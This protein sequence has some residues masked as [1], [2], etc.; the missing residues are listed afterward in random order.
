VRIL[1]CYEV[2]STDAFL[3]FPSVRYMRPAVRAFSDI[4]VPALKRLEGWLAKASQL[5]LAV[6]GV[7]ALFAFYIPSAALVDW[8]H[9]P[10]GRLRLLKASERTEKGGCPAARANQRCPKNS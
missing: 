4:L 7:V 8:R 10:L 5:R 1:P 9:V 6:I 3:A 2:K